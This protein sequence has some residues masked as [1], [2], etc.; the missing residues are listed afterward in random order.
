MILSKKRQLTCLTCGGNIVGKAYQV[1]DS[2]LHLRC[3]FCKARIS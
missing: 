1:G 2:D 3:P